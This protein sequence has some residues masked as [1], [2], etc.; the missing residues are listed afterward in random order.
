MDWKALR[1]ADPRKPDGPPPA[2]M[3]IGQAAEYLGV[4]PWYMIRRVRKGELPCRMVKKRPRIPKAALDEEN[5][6]IFQRAKDGMEEMT[7]ISEELGLYDDLLPKK[8]Q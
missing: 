6:R 7:R 8:E 5:E 3:T 4:S 1:A 2:E